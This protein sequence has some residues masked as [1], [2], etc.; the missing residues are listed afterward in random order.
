MPHDIGLLRHLH[1]QSSKRHQTLDEGVA[2]SQQLI[3]SL[4][5]FCLYASENKEH[6]ATVL[7][8]ILWSLK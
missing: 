1:Y 7:R 2:Q 4:Q 6:S 3:H 8:E 5:D